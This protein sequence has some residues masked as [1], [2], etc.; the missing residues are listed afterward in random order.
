MC[1]K[2]NTTFKCGSCLQAFCYNNFNN[3]RH[4]LSKHL[5]EF[6]I[7]HDSFQQT[8]EM[9]KHPEETRQRLFEHE[10]HHVDDI[11]NKLTTQRQQSR[12]E[13]DYLKLNLN[14]WKKQLTELIEELAKVSSI[15]IR[16]HS[17]S[18]INKINAMVSS[19]AYTIDIQTKRIITY[20]K[21]HNVKDLISMFIFF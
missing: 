18:F 20:P 19:S 7:T 16:Q 15:I 4:H 5:E 13:N 2:D 10:V 11:E 6:E 1:G 3:H 14:Q 17:I 21:V 8:A 9:Q 12:Q